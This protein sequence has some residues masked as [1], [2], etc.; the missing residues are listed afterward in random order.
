[1]PND[2]AHVADTM[3]PVEAGLGYRRPLLRL[4]PID[5]QARSRS[6]T[7]RRPTEKP[8]CARSPGS[9]GTFAGPPAP[10]A[11]VARR[12]SLGAAAHASAGSTKPR[13]YPALG[14]QHTFQQG[15]HIEVGVQS[16]K[17]DAQPK[18][19]DLDLGQVVARGVLQT[20]GIARREA[21]FD[22]G[23]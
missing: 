18:S 1:M 2:H 6:P 16:R 15:W 13:R 4:D 7:P 5:P 8:S 23:R 11:V 19:L 10:L 21:D 17:M 22:A 9:D 12:C 14:A 20:L 3:L